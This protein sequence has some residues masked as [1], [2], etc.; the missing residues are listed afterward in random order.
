VSRKKLYTTVVLACL[1]G[2]IWLGVSHYL[3]VAGDGQ[4]A[5]TCPFR[6]VTGMPCPSCGSTGSVLSLISGDI[7]AALYS[8]PAG[9]LIA[10][11]MFIIP[12]WIIVD[13]L[14]RKSTFHRF[15]INAEK[16]LANRRLAIPAVLLVVV[17]WIWNFYK[18]L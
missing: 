7:G 8:N 10:T 2:Y 3:N 9:F 6:H 18:Y 13:L 11:I 12:L 14:S 5:G 17:N 4:W 15:Y 16:R 1:A